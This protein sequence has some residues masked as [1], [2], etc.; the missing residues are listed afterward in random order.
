[1]SI[2]EIENKIKNVICIANNPQIVANFAS[3]GNWDGPHRS[4]I[5]RGQSKSEWDFVPSIFRSNISE[6]WIL[7]Q[8]GE[9][10]NYFEFSERELKVIRNFVKISDSVGLKVPTDSY[11]FRTRD[12]NRYLNAFDENFPPKENIEIWA[13]AQ[14]HGI[15]TR[16]LDFSHNAFYAA[17][18]AAID[19]FEKGDFV[20]DLT[21]LALNIGKYWEISNRR[22]FRRIQLVSVPTYDNNYLFSQ[23]GIFLY[24]KN[25]QDRWKE[26][27]QSHEIAVFSILDAFAE[28]CEKLKIDLPDVI[29]MM[30]Y[31][32]HKVT[33]LL[34]HL[35]KNDINLAGLMPNYD[36]IK[37]TMEIERKIKF[38][39][40]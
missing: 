8:K 16:L 32:K 40:M 13:I 11:E 35:H 19:S 9:K 1:M 36:S 28:E 12:A 39:R 26:E 38:E 2:A 23:K 29:R 21:V 6:E 24:D 15:P 18:F 25:I 31:P 34:L 30:K 14:H 37:K 10:I 4:W 17:F 3:I 33:D 22:E 27:K 20:G 5:F 7:R